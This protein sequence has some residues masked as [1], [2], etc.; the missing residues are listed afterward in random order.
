MLFAELAATSDR[1]AAT[2]KKLEKTALLAEAVRRLAPEELDA[3]VRFLAGQI[4]QKK[5]GVG[6]ASIQNTFDAAPAEAATL[7]VLEVDR[8]LQEI[9]DASGPGSI[10]KKASLL[11]SMLA[12]ATRSEQLFV[13]GLIAGGVRQGA[14]E[15][16]IVDAIARAANV[17]S[18]A[19]RRAQMVAVDLGRV[20]HA[21]LTEGEPGLSRFGLSLFSPVQPMLAQTASSVGEV[22]E[23]FHPASFELKLDG[24]RV[25]VHKAGDEVRVYTR[26]LNEATE[27]VPEVIEAVRALPIDQLILDG[28]VIALGE[29]DAPLPFQTTMRRFGRRTDVENQRRE[30]P[31]RTFFFDALRIGDETLVGAPASARIEAMHQ[32]LP[33]ALRVPRLITGELEK[34]QAFMKDALDRGHE[35]VM[36][37][38]LDAPYEAGNR[39]SGWLKLKVAHTLDLVVI[40]VEHGSGRREGHLSNI[41]LGARDEASGQFIMLG[42][43]FKG[44]TDEMLAWQTRRFLELETHRDGYVVYVRPEQ[45]VEIAF[46]DVQ[47]SPHYPA[48]MALRFA[49]VKRY[50][51]DKSAQEADTLAAVRALHEKSNG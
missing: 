4:R 30:L 44:M 34:A 5:L 29:D 22:L 16:L 50:R 47:T 19:V 41:H 25:Q 28:E 23:R 27:R 49:R 10:K 32:T 15:S 45:V 20:A 51:D 9:A 36:A 42:K 1:V 31:L 33:E 12:K 8:A 39:G 38:S 7:P 6:Y 17:P 14:L 35:G 48:G 13:R 24:A 18:S 37:K 46:A 26:R 40:A 3:G 2:S 11:G 21:A 43:T